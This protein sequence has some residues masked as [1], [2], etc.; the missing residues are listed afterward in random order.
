MADGVDAEID[1]LYGEPLD[2]FTAERNDAA[3]RLAR[4]GDADGAARVK[5]LEKPSLVAWTINQLAR[6][7]PEELAGLLAAGDELRSAHEQVLRDGGGAERIHAA[8][9][10]ERRAVHALVEAAAEILGEAGRASRANLDRVEATLRAAAVDPEAR[11]LLETGRLTREVEPG[12]FGALAGIAL[13]ARP[14][15]RRETGPSRAEARRRE[16]EQELEQAV[17]E[18]QREAQHADAEAA[19]AAKAADE[20]HRRLDRAHAALEA[21]RKV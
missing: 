10:E 17:R 3:K 19:R 8:E 12:G 1:R 14:P 6:R 2:R 13:P 20:A 16:R 18:A 7:R 11:E 4:D 5:A 9:A 21:H 15:G